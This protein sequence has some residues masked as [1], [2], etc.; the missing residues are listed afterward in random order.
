MAIAKS[1]LQKL[2]DP[3]TSPE[4]IRRYLE[5]GYS[6]E[7]KNLAKMHPG[8]SFD[9]WKKLFYACDPFAWC[10]PLVLLHLFEHE[11]EDDERSKL[12]VAVAAARNCAMEFYKFPMNGI[13]LIATYLGYFENSESFTP[14]QYLQFTSFMMNFGQRDPWTRHC[15]LGSACLIRLWIEYF[16]QE[17][18]DR[19]ARIA[20]DIER[21]SLGEPIDPED[22][23]R[24][25]DKAL[26]EA[27]HEDASWWWIVDCLQRSSRI[28]AS[29]FSENASENMDHFKTNIRRVISELARRRPTH[30]M[31]QKVHDLNRTWVQEIREKGRP[32]SEL[33]LNDAKAAE[34][35][36]LR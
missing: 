7:V 12:V 26:D 18:P 22:L 36:M 33:F 24:R 34:G 17:E 9:E 10:S 19:Y 27:T 25:T 5:G 30:D 23:L 31:A 16:F 15:A 21:W 1:I 2:E 8:L 6:K 29:H 11:G 13:E 4:V 35:K 28:V 32:L 20:T 14:G 3:D